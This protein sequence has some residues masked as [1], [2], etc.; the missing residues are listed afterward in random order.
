MPPRRGGTMLH[1][2]APV[3]IL[4]LAAPLLVVIAGVVAELIVLL[5]VH[6]DHGFWWA[7]LAF[8]AVLLPCVAIARL[9]AGVTQRRAI[10]QHGRPLAPG[11]ARY[12][13]RCGLETRTFD[14][15]CTFCGG[16]RFVA[17]P[18]LAG[19]PGPN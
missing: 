2:N 7:M 11:E 9:L 13:A 10:E 19:R 1:S 12:C 8:A 18:P 17:E 16:T 4:P 14:P 3:P 6:D 15:T 5:N